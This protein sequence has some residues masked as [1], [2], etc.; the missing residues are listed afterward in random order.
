MFLEK[1]QE[2]KD[3]ISASSVNL[4][5]GTPILP[6]LESLAPSLILLAAHMKDVLWVSRQGN[7]IGMIY[8]GFITNMALAA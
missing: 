6:Y 3:G 5:N 1:L 2:K 8:V 7:V 4:K